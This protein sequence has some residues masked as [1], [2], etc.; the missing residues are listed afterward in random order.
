MDHVIR[1][2][3]EQSIQELLVQLEDEIQKLEDL[4]VETEASLAEMKRKRLAG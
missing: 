4:I 1:N 2:D 3:K